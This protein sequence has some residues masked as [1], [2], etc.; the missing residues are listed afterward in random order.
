MAQ[1]SFKEKLV[2]YLPDWL[3]KTSENDTV[4]KGTKKMQADYY[5]TGGGY[6]M[7]FAYSFTG[8]K[9]LGEI[10]PAKNYL[11]NY[12]ILRVRSWQSY[13]ESEIAQTVMNRF[14]TW[15]VGSGLKL[16]S[17]P[18]LKVLKEEGIEFDSHNFTEVVESRFNVYRKSE[19]SDFTEMQNLDF[20]AKDA[21]KNAIIGGDVLVVLRY[22]NNS[23]SVQL[24]DGAHVQS[25]NFGTE[26][27][28]HQLENGN[29]IING[30]E[31]TPSGKHVKYHIRTATGKFES[32]DCR[33]DKSGMQMAFL[34]YGL[35]Y[36][37]N[38][39]RGLPFLSVVLETLKKLERYKEATVGSAEER[40][41][42]AFAIE[43]Q[44]GSTG[45]NPLIQNLAKAINYD[46]NTTELPTDINGAELARTVAATTN[47]QAIN[48]PINATLKMLESKNEL[49]FKEFYSVNIDCIC[50][51]LGI[52]PEVAMSKYDSNFSAARAALKDWENT[53]II[54]RHSFSF[55]FYQ[56]IY[57]FWLETEILKNKITAPGYLIAKIKKDN[58][59]LDS[60]RSARFVGPPVPHID[61]LKEVKAEREKL[62]ILG[63]HLPLTTL[64]A[65]TE[66]LNSGESN[67]NIIQFG[68]ELQN[69]IKEKI[70]KEATELDPGKSKVEE[71]D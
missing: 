15:V 35:R 63:E 43:H 48:M 34:V 41:K 67:S 64:E 44:M 51:C 53:L 18:A 5:P 59:I 14:I 20:I 24:I 58:V 49:Y 42:I 26:G 6:N 17:E 9:N 22:V 12:G 10:G 16:Q 4:D 25:P 27:S 45:E 54:A 31:E 52:P 36:R 32:I 2:S 33:G 55:Q 38:N 7:L 21:Y 28:P 23:V 37:L 30:V 50:A 61:P 57:N 40:Q 69:A 68:K 71:E 56:K 13:L 19:R 29:R 65:A 46:G 70:A 66:S 3:N 60:Y 8:E 39:N 47:K 62:G 11:P 1:L